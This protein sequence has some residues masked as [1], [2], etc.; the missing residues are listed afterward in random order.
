MNKYRDI[1]HGKRVDNDKWVEGYLIRP[2]FNPNAAYIGYLFATDDH[3]IDV[4]EVDPSTLGRCTG[5]RD[6]N[7][8]LIFEGN[9]VEYS[10]SI[11][12]VVLYRSVVKIGEYNQDGSSGEYDPIQCCGV[13]V[14]VTNYTCPD[15]L[16]PDDEDEIWWCPQYLAQQNILEIANRCEVVGDIHDDKTTN[17]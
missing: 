7:G 5:L 1:W 4:A 8:T 11:F 10:C 3:D 12:D 15:W 9:I 2:E 6:K 17:A 14:E 13:Y 16:A